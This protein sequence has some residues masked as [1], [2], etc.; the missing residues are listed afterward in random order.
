MANNY[1]LGKGKLFFDPW[2][3]SNNTTGE[4]AFGNCPG[5]EISV[6]ST[7]LEHFSSESGIKQKDDE[8]LLEV[9]RSASIT[10]DNITENNM[11]LFIIGTASTPSQASGSVVDE[12]ITVKKDRY[13]QLGYSTSNP[14]GVRNVSSVVVTDNAGTTTYASGT[15]YTLDATLA[16]IYI[17]TTSTI[18]DAQVI[19]VDY[20]KAAVSRNQVQS[21][22]LTATTG[23]LRFVAD[24]PKG[25]NRDLYAPKVN[26]K[27][28]GSYK[29]IGD[30]WMEVA[31]NCE[32]L[33]K[34]TSTPALFIDGRAA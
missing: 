28:N 34:D 9:T 25:T 2:D 11:A 31:F 17:P 10:C 29:W 12:V 24:N 33:Q 1:V 8:V 30:T 4:R 6:N 19:K 15:D 27:P 20:T 23:A 21:A 16:R 22:S 13:Y 3:S 26:L 18:T 5:F 14:S 7:S 32:F